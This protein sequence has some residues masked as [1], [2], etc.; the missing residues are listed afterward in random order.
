M[1]LSIPKKILIL[2]TSDSGGAGIAIYRFY[3]GLKEL[4]YDTKLVVKIKTQNDAEVIQFHNKNKFILINRIIK[5]INKKFKNKSFAHKYKTISDYCFYDFYENKFDN[6]FEG[7]ELSINFIPDIIIAAWGSNFLNFKSLGELALKFNAK[8]FFL[9]NDM[10]HLTGGCHYNWSCNGYLEG[11]INCPAIIET[12]FKNQPNQNILDKRKSINQYNI[13]IIAGSE[14]TKLQASNSFLF[15]TQSDIQIFNGLIDFN[16]FNPLKRTIAKHV[17]DIPSDAKVIFCGAYDFKEKRKGFNELKNVL[18]E[19]SLIDFSFK[20]DI[21]VLVVG[22]IQEN[23][24]IPKLKFKFINYINDQ[25]LLSLAYQC[26]DVFVSP[27]IED[28]GPMMVVESLACGT[29]V[30]GFDIGLVSSLISNGENGFKIK[31]FDTLNMSEKIVEILS[32]KSNHFN[33]NC[34]N[35]VK[36]KFSLNSLSEMVQKL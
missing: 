6:V 5:K 3:Q 7:Y 20:S 19:L 11:C 25:L 4:G 9:M 23:I 13:K 31:N 12:E 33:N 10:G 27:S 15:K 16:I 1:V 22:N 28:C 17:F 8:S 35:T 26:S 24:I 14:L 36:Y 34:I 30:I 21:I 2:S 32:F 18:Y 29:P